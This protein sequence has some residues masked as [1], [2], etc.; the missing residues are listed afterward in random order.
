VNPRLPTYPDAPWSP[1]TRLVRSVS[2]P[3]LLCGGTYFFHF[4]ALGFASFP[5]QTHLRKV[6]NPSSASLVASVT[7][8]AACLTYF[9]FR[10]AESRLWTRSPERMLA[11]V[12]VLVALLQL[13]LG[14]RLHEIGGQEWFLGPAID[15]ATCMLLL[16]CAHS[17]CMTLLNHIGVATLGPY[18]F[19]VRAAGSAGY[20]LAVV[21]M[22]A[23]WTE[24][25]VSRLHLFIAC[26]ISIVHAA[27]ATAGYLYL[28]LLRQSHTEAA[29]QAPWQRA[30]ET[31]LPELDLDHSHEVQREQPPHPQSSFP[32]TNVAW[33]GLLVLVWMVAM[34]EMSYGLYAHEFLTGLYGN[35]G[36]FIFAGAIAIE[37]ALLLG[38][39][40]LP[41]LKERLLFVGPLGWVAL[42][43]G[44]LL[45]IS[46]LLPMGVMAMA[47][48]L[49]CPFQ[50]S[51]NEHAH[52]M[53]P[54]ILGVASMS[55]AQSLGYVTA[56]MTSALVSEASTGPRNL[57]LCMLPVAA[58]ALGLAIWKL[59]LHKVEWKHS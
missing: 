42:L 38:M 51:A 59:S 39:P 18:A 25:S 41:S 30:P 46:G 22:G 7:P 43:T 36:Y 57:W 9:L 35:L 19:T 44:C 28:K 33:W 52:R 40:W 58:L 1:L 14:W 16:G 32:G 45:A 24:S 2:I 17:S 8:I 11:I 4:L 47:L 49:N 15:A 34:C 27:V 23:L 53:N 48:S 29:E 12:A 55:L 56:T 21:L 37:I 26:G 54:S 10:F 3:V 13:L 20:M 5:L 50:V 31:Q 6:L